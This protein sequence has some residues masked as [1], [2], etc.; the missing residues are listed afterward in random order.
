MA[1]VNHG[2]Q[3]LDK[4]L[5]FGNAWSYGAQVVDVDGNT[6]VRLFLENYA[7]RPVK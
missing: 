1:G 2:H 7:K 4:E 6:S 5:D 3:K